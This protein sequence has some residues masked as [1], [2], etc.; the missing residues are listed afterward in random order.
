[1]RTMTEML[2]AAIAV[3][4][5]IRFYAWIAGTLDLSQAHRAGLRDVVPATALLL[6][7]AYLHWLGGTGWAIAA[8]VVGLTIASTPW[9]GLPALPPR[10]LD[11]QA[12][13][14]AAT[15]MA[16]VTQVGRH[17]E[18]GD[19]LSESQDP[20]EGADP[21]TDFDEDEEWADDD[22]LDTVQD[23]DPLSAAEATAWRDLADR[24]VLN[25]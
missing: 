21:W 22:G 15:P 6:H 12:L 1:M 8:A 13:T 5:T 16:P 25:D 4:I 7:I 3:F 11:E 24:F 9:R 10:G 19:A 18:V 23:G 2:P 17:D 14:R 20:T